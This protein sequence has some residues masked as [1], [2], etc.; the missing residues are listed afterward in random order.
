MGACGSRHFISRENIEW[1]GRTPA[2]VQRAFKAARSR[3]AAERSPADLE[4]Q[5]GKVWGD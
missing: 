3:A 2:R 5:F 1:R 4:K